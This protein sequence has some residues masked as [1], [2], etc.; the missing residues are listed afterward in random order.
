MGEMMHNLDLEYRIDSLT[1][2]LGE[3]NK[4]KMFGGIGYLLNGN[5]CFGI[6]KEYLILRTTAEKA[7]DFLK[8][9]YIK[10][11]DITGKP[12]KGWLMIS[13]DYVETDDQLESVLKLGIDLAMT[14]PRK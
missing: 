4:K 2:R 9:E 14:L 7:E 1:G 3:I 13:P 11:F 8:N 6:H 5:M 10:P 12:M